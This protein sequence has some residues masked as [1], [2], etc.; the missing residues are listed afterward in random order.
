MS[1]LGIIVS[2]VFANNIIL[3]QLIVGQSFLDITRDIKTS[4]SFGLV[5]SAMAALCCLATWA[6]YHAVLLPLGLGYLQTLT[7]IMLITGLTPLVD[8]C[9]AKTLPAPH[10][11]LRAFFPLVS[12][13]CALLGICLISVRS[14]YSALESLLAGAAAGAGYSL[15]LVLLATMREAMKKEWIPRPF[16]GVPITL[17]SA[18]LM[19]LAFMAFDEALLKNLLK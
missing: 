12:T 7:F 10:S 16:Q 5:L 1:Y 17:I 3:S 11:R 6:L 18:G 19:A 9:L 14:G 15:A 2:L 13:N 4:L 8:L